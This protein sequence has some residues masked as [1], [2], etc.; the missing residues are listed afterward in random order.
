MRPSNMDRKSNVNKEPLVDYEEQIEERPAVTNF[1]LGFLILSTFGL[2][3][4]V[5]FVL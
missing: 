4:F 2:I 3:V 5:F 1:K